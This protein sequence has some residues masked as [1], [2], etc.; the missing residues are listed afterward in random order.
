MGTKIIIKD[1][2]LSGDIQNQIEISVQQN[3]ISIE[4]IIK[5]RVYQE[6]NA[7]NVQQ[8]AYFKGL[9]QPTEAEK[10]LNGYKLRKTKYIDPEKQYYLAL[11][12]FKKNQFFVLVNNQQVTELKTVISLKKINE[13][14]FLKLVPLVGG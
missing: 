2:S 12:A 1:E 3:S 10:V 14:S 8:P 7:Y 13:V 11:D 9:V 4:E 6:V 5:E